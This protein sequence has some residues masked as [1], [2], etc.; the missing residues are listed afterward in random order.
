MMAAAKI[1]FF[2]DAIFVNELSVSYF[3]KKKTDTMPPAAAKYLF[4]FFIH[5]S[6]LLPG[7]CVSADVREITMEML[8]GDA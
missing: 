1:R 4:P 3:Q 7:N 2:E 8:I 6:I 5:V